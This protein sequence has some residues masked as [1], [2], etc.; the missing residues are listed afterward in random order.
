MDKSHCIVC[1]ITG[2]TCDLPEISDEFV[3]QIVDNIHSPFLD[4]VSMDDIQIP[5]DVIDENMFFELTT[6]GEDQFSR[7]NI[8]ED[9]DIPNDD[10]GYIKHNIT[11]DEI[12]IDI[13]PGK[14]P[15]PENPSHATVVIAQDNKDGQT[16]VTR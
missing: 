14:R 13:D 1:E 10:V 8:R 11:N 3:N 15:M 12:K 2:D 6:H 4:D 16:Q 7:V 5:F 9:S